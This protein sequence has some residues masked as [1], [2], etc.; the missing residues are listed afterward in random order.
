MRKDLMPQARQLE[1]PKGLE[2]DIS[3]IALDRWNPSM[4]CAQKTDATISILGRIG[5]DPFTGEGVTDSRIAGALRSIG[6]ENDVTVSINS[7][8]GDLNQGIAIYNLLRE[9]KGQVTVKILS[10]AAS[11]ASIIAMAGD[12]IQIARAGFLMVH[13]SWLIVMGN[14]HD[15]RDFADYIE[16]F[17]QA[18]AEIYAARTQLDIKTIQKKMDAETLINGTAAVDEGWADALLPAD[19]I[20]SGAHAAQRSPAQVIEA[21]LTKD[22]MPRSLRRSVI[23]EFKASMLRAAGLYGMPRATDNDTPCAVAELL[24]AIQSIRI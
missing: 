1:R 10:M 21:A 6:A 4:V 14:R 22:G 9:H 23:Q 13:N 7:I 11:A 2:W 12:E 17:D 15:L 24:N 20:Q 3:P 5:I 8:G 16:P 18:M 19:E